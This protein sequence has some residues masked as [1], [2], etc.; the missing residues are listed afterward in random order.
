MKIPSLWLNN[1]GMFCMG[2]ACA[3][4]P[5]LSGSPDH[6]RRAGELDVAAEDAAARIRKSRKREQPIPQI[7]L[8]DAEEKALFR[9]FISDLPDDLMPRPGGAISELLREMSGLGIGEE[10]YWSLAFL[11]ISEAAAH[12]PE[13]VFKELLGKGDPAVR[14]GYFVAVIGKWLEKDPVAVEKAISQLPAGTTRDLL[15]RLRFQ[16]LQARNP[17]VAYEILG[18]MENAQSSDYRKIFASLAKTDP[19]GSISKLSEIMGE[20][21]RKS[22]ILGIAAS[23]GAANTQRSLEWA[24]RLDNTERELAVTMIINSQVSKDM[25]AAIRVIASLENPHDRVV[26]IRGNL[27]DIALQDPSKAFTLASEN[28]NGRDLHEAVSTIIS[29]PI[30]EKNSESLREAVEALPTGESRDRIL[31]EFATRWSQV[32]PEAVYSWL[33]ETGQFEIL[34]EEMQ[35]RL[36][37]GDIP[38]PSRSQIINWGK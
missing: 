9:W 34:P 1:A 18:K 36:A 20:E 6:S 29:V 7:G 8:G 3:S 23:F 14:E 21:K 19:D 24:A 22:A 16:E 27:Q 30:N 17:E 13:R 33:T 28:L 37:N 38:S 31:I 2:V 15:E 4:F 35:V 26:A 10:A 32:N 11:A 25:P 5:F 12:D